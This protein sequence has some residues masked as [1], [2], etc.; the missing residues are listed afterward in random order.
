MFVT[1]ML[2]GSL[3]V[4]MQGRKQDH[5]V[6]LTG[7]LATFAVGNKVQSADS[8]KGSLQLSNASLLVPP[9]MHVDLTQLLRL[10]CSRHRGMLGPVQGQ[11]IRSHNRHNRTLRCSLLTAKFSP[12][13]WK[14]HLEG[15]YMRHQNLIVILIILICQYL[16]GDITECTTNRDSSRGI[17]LFP[18]GELFLS[19]GRI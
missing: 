6:A 5:Q 3:F 7:S 17:R 4:P 14:R 15:I 16:L 18:D 19:D 9:E 1:G 2:P 12:A 8:G 13:S 10:H 11:Q